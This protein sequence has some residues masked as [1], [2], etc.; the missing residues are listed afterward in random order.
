MPG[1]VQKLTG[2]E[3]IRTMTQEKE[4]CPFNGEVGGG[5]EGCPEEQEA[6]L[7]SDWGWGQERPSWRG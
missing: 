5:L 6:L 4:Q 1:P 2:G 7:D 3:G